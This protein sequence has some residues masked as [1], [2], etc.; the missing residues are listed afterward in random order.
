MVDVGWTVGMLAGGWWLVDGVLVDGG[1]WVVDDGCWM[2]DDR[3][4]MVGCV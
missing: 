2:M 4:W 1:W 3:W